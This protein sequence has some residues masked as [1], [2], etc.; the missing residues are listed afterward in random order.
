MVVFNVKIL[1]PVCNLTSTDTAALTNTVPSVG[2]KVSTSTITFAFATTLLTDIWVA[3]AVSILTQREGDL[4][5]STDPVA[6]QPFLPLVWATSISM[7]AEKDGYVRNPHALVI[8]GFRESLLKLFLMDKV[9]VPLVYTQVSCYSLVFF[10]V[11]EL[12]VSD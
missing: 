2:S 11:A 9:C 6:A 8:N 3:I 10:Q 12:L 4:I 1:S 7:R 5:D